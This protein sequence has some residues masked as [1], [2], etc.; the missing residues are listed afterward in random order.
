LNWSANSSNTIFS[1]TAVLP[2]AAITAGFC[3]I[4]P[5]ELVTGV[6]ATDVVTISSSADWSTITGYG[7]AATDG[8]KVYAW[9]QNNA[10]NFKLCNGS[11]A[12]ITPGAATL[13]IRVIR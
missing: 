13:N 1:G 2:T 12:S 10:V 7:P 3:A 6:L 8:L 4:G 9:P 5:Q 11:G